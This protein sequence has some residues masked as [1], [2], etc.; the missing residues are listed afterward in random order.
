MSNNGIPV[1]IV[2]KVGEGRPN[3]VDVIKNRQTDL[4][5]NTPSGGRAHQKVA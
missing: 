2:E 4:I 5:I 3:V 1:E